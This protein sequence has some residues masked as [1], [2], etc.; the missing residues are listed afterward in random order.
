MS[1]KLVKM[2]D[3]RKYVGGSNGWYI[4]KKTLTKSSKRRRSSNVPAW[5]KKFCQEVGLI[6]WKKLVNAKMYIY[7][8]D[9][10]VQWND[11]AAEEAF[12]KAK[13]RYWSQINDEPCEIPLPNPDMYIDEIDWNSEM[14]DLDFLQGI[15][16]DDS[17]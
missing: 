17:F 2:A 4:L 12:K 14:F 13:L 10:V 16:D 11:S 5:E 3:L 6:P 1:F 8:F 15:D 7:G 9:H